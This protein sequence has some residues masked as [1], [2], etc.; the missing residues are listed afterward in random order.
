MKSDCA[1]PLPSDPETWAV[2]IRNNQRKRRSLKKV[3]SFLFVS[4]CLFLLIG[5]AVGSLFAKADKYSDATR[6]EV[7]AHRCLVARGYLCGMYL[8]ELLGTVEI[9]RNMLTERETPEISDDGRLVWRREA[10][11]PPQLNERQVEAVFESR[12]DL[13][14]EKLTR[15]AML[16]AEM[17]FGAWSVSVMILAAWLALH[18][19]ASR[20]RAIG[21]SLARLTASPLNFL[22]GSGRLIWHGI[23]VAWQ[24]ARLRSEVRKKEL[25]ARKLIAEET[26]RRHGIDEAE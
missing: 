13:F 10:V 5:T 12:S 24:S 15:K 23:A 2:P 26:L 9:S 4:L 11:A 6:G 7:L 8:D 3:I 22:D 21:G 16:G 20:R 1:F 19:L 25:L 17:A 18:L 14:K